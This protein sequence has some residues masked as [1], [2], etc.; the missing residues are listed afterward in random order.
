MYHYTE[1]GLQNVWLENGY[2]KVRTKYGTGVAIHDVDGL[3]RMIG[4]TIARKPR[5]TGAEFR[6][7]RKQLG[8]TDSCAS[9]ISN[10][11]RTTRGSAIS[12]IA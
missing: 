11:Q 8:R 1:S 10:T 6:F 4:K 3:H 12:S 2:S 9:S 5:M 7:L